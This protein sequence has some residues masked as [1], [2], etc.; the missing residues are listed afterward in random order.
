VTCTVHS[1]E[2]W[3][4]VAVRMGRG[5][6]RPGLMAAAEAILP[7]AVSVMAIVVLATVEE[8]TDD[9]LALRNAAS[10]LQPAAAGCLG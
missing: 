3:P 9:L 7:G 8:V 10:Q 4:D 2:P 6:R 1:C 5:L